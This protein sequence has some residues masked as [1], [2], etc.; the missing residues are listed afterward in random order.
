MMKAKEF[1][2]PVQLPTGKEERGYYY[3][4]DVQNWRRE[5]VSVNEIN[6][7]ELQTPY[8]Y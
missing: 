1:G 3:F 4:F 5:R 8:S 7:C 6:A 2:E